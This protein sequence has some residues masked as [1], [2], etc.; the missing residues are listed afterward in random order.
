MK[1]YD[2]IL[3]TIGH[4]PIVRLKN[5][6]KSGHLHAQLY[7]KIESFN[8]GG[9][10]KDRIALSMV[11]NAEKKGRLLP[12]HTIIEPT[13][14]NTGIGLAMVAAAKGYRIILVMPDTASIERRKILAAFGAKLILTDGAK[15]INE[16]IIVAKKLHRST[17]NSFMPM[18][19]NNPANPRIH[20]QTTAREIFRAMGDDIAAFISGI[21]T[22]GTISGVG[23]YLRKKIPLIHLVGLE[24][25]KSPILSQGWKG[26]HKI[27]GIGAGFIPK[28]LNTLI[29]DEIMTISNEAAFEHARM[30]A[31]REGILAGISSGAALDGAIKIARRASF[32]GKNILMIL[33]DTGE[34]YLSTELVTSI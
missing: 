22:G 20:F 19:F 34:R 6:E 3:D 5:I 24:P 32:Y 16:A 30:L 18:Q 25:E 27:Q 7:A 31:E 26:S 14:G 28:T 11:L 23:K 1:T 10:I 9:S 4:T 13:S 33:P 15:G 21:G 12:G 17:P 29:Y 8:P 2:S